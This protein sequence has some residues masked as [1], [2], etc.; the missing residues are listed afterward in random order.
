[1]IFIGM[2]NKHMQ[3]C[4]KREA[5]LYKVLGVVFFILVWQ[6]AASCVH[7]IVL[8]SPF[9]TVQALFA[10][11]NR[12]FLCEHFFLTLTRMLASVFLGFVGGFAAG[13]LA[14]I[15]IRIR[16]M[17]EPFRWMLMSIPA[18]VFLV[19]IML[20]LGMGSTMI[21]AFSSCMLAP[22][23]YVNTVKGMDM[24]EREL[25][26]M[27]KVYQF[28]CYYKIREIYL[29]SITGPVLSSLVVITG[30]G[31]RIIVLS[32]LMGASHGLGAFLSSARTNLAIPELY[33][34]VLLCLFVVGGFEYSILRP[35]QKYILRWKR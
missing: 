19:I 9:D 20:L 30:N 33:A 7:S 34:C 15:D 3:V 17:L 23:V 8:A 2:G 16:Y 35:L 13:I 1:M 11:L 31:L 18:I 27:A 12:E 28:G 6:L 5:L 25:L 29:P 14:G 22:F 10:L 26:E 32:E 4:T 21:I 24:I